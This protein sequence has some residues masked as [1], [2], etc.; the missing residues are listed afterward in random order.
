VIQNAS[1]DRSGSWVAKP[2]Q[3]VSEEQIKAH[4]QGLVEKGIITSYSV[5]DRIV[6]VETLPRTS[7]GKLDKKV[8]RNT[9][10]HKHKW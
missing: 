2:C 5:P 4:L 1:S 9:T 8:I 3:E 6:F 10:P 7:V